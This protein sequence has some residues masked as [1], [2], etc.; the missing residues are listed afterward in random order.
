MANNETISLPNLHLRILKAE[1]LYKK[2]FFSRIPFYL[3][4]PDPFAVVTADGQQTHTTVADRQTLSPHWNAECELVVTPSTLVSIQIFDQKRFKKEHQGFMGVASFVVGA[5]MD[6]S[7]AG[8]RSLTIELGAGNSSEPVRGSVILILTIKP[9][10]ES[11][12]SEQSLNTMIQHDEHGT[13][14][15]GWE[16]RLDKFGHPF[17]IDHNT[18]TTTWVRPSLNTPPAVIERRQQEIVQQQR[19]MH[20]ARTLPT[21]AD[22]GL[23]AGWEQRIA[24]NGQPYYINH[25]TQQT[26]WHRPTPAPTYSDPLAGPERLLRIYQQSVQQ[27]GELPQG[28]EMREHNNGQIY[29]VDH[30]THSTTWDDP[31]LPSAADATCPEYR[32]TF[33]QKLAFFRSQPELRLLKGQTYIDIT[34]ANVFMDAFAAFSKLS[35]DDLKR[36]LTFRFDG[37]EGLDY[38]G[39]SRE[40]F[41]LLSHEIFNPIYCLFEYSSHGQYTLQISPRSDINPEHLEYFRFIGRIVGV[42][43]FHQRFLDA[44]FVSAFYKQILGMEVTPEDLESVDPDLWRGITWMQQNDVSCLMYHFSVDDERFGV[45][46]EY[47][48]KEGGR[49]I[50]VTNENK[51]EY[52]ELLTQWRIVK[53]V[54]EQMQAFMSGLFEII[55]KR[56]L[57][58]FDNREIELLIGG[59]TE[60]DLQD[61]QRYTDYRNCEPGDPVVGMFWRAVTESFDNEQ[62]AKL[63]Q[64][65]TGTS[66][67]PVNGFKG[68]QGSDGPRHFTIEVITGNTD[69]LPMA[70]TCFNRIDLPRYSSYEVMLEKLSIAIEHSIGF[71]QE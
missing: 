61:W 50:E 36:R 24:P 48:L 45:V 30:N 17:Y 39:V 21:L 31:R 65:V 22:S 6:I 49:N 59:V 57:D 5:V 62:R 54:Q 4:L 64:F 40:F 29:F 55:P 63:I 11:L 9:N 26:T 34:R 14:P 2:S 7:Q 52:I 3:E 8:S 18:R 67:L 68:L 42:A 69:R 41:F 37:E 66:R 35:P 15:P 1:N 32:R 51:D 23:P 71:A 47:E 20:E 60:I 25:N 43:I 12:V 13:L 38:G 56:L 53:R 27:L 33:Q 70:H 46:Q 58:I 19:I 10:T 44:F 16:R 28:W